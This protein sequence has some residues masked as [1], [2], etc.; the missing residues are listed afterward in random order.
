MIYTRR[1]QREGEMCEREGRGESLLTTSA[2][3]P[4][5]ESDTA[6]LLLLMDKPVFSVWKRNENMQ[7]VCHYRELQ[8]GCQRNE[9]EE[10]NLTC[11]GLSQGRK[12]ALREQ[13]KTE[14]FCGEIV[15]SA[16]LI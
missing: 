13:S 3:L 11:T 15:S 5:S 7:P 12:L 10:M 6:T 16:N 1:V 4:C 2:L 8:N 14:R 9:G